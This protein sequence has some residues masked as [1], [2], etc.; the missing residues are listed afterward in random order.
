MPPCGA[1]ARKGSGY[2]T[3][4]PACITSVSY[5]HLPS[6]T[7]EGYEARLVRDREGRGILHLKAAAAQGLFYAWQSMVCLLY[8]SRCV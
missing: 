1:H 8:T 5:T 4:T 2:L 3:L 7:G 6:G